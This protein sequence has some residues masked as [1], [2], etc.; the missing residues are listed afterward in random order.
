MNAPAI[1]PTVNVSVQQDLPAA[2]TPDFAGW[3]KVFT[4]QI[5]DFDTPSRGEK[6]KVRLRRDFRRN[7][8]NVKDERERGALLQ[9]ET[10]IPDRTIETNLRRGKAPRVKYL[11][12][13]STVLSFVDPAQ[14]DANFEQLSSYYTDIN[15]RTGWQTEW[16]YLSDAIEL[17]G[18]GYL[19][20]FFDPTTD[21]K[22]KVEY[23]QRDHLIYPEGTKS[24]NS[25]ASILRRFDITKETFDEFAKRYGFDESQA[26]KIREYYK[27]RE[28][29]TQIHRAY[30]RI[31]GVINV[32]WIGNGSVSLDNWL[33]PP[34]PYDI[35]LRR[36]DEMTGTFLPIPVTE[37][38]IFVFPFDLEEDCDILKVQGRASL[39][40]H[41]Q[42]AIGAI[43]TAV[44]NGSVR[45]AGL[46]P[47]RKPSPDDPTPARNQEAMVLKH[48]NVYHGDFTF[49]KLEWP[50]AV[51][52]S[53]AQFIR[54]NNAQ[55]AGGVDFAAM[56]RADTA[57]TATE[58]SLAQQAADE[59]SSSS[60]TLFALC[61]LRV[62][63]LRWQI[64]LSQVAS[65]LSPAPA[66]A[67]PTPAQDGTQLPPAI[68]IFSPSL[69][70]TMSADQQV[71]RRAADASKR[72]QYFPYVQGTPYQLPFIESMLKEAFPKEFTMWQQQ[73]S[74]INQLQTAAQQSLQLIAHSFEILRSI[75]AEA[76]PPEDRENYAKFL[77]S[78]GNYLAQNQPAN[79]Q[80]P[81]Q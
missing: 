57:K 59:L 67:Q 16:L 44:V 56:N 8:V 7:H 60:I 40:L 30:L 47:T 52:V 41:V 9:D 62:E 35:G 10:R 15:R 24:L 27:A 68:D 65:G 39:D 26:Q 6:E 19:E 18:A 34:E 11:T 5:Q 79:A 51:A 58:L 22:S 3:N 12:Q 74:A 23:I 37:C 73:V 80:Q 64:W 42:E 32:A 25:C 77:N 43:L 28:E 46:Y 49:G 14:P 70:P 69:I 48:G 29:F 72:I 33:K 21:I 63:L 53:I 81:A 20:V 75:K 4:K 38:P 31:N 55:Q 45:A 66:F 54:T 78:L 61:C 71:V 76:I 13:T 17:H 2:Q 1:F 50:S 36:R